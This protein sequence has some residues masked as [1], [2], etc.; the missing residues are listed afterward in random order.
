M[1]EQRLNKS[2]AESTALIICVGN[3][4]LISSL[5]RRKLLS[6]YKDVFLAVD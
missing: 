6:T 5:A 2:S 1:K 3:M 4:G